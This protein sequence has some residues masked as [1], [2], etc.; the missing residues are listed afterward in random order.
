MHGTAELR[1]WL[2]LLLSISPA[3]KILTKFGQADGRWGEMGKIAKSA[4]RALNLIHVMDAFY[5]NLLGQRISAVSTT[6]VLS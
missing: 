4:F 2:G 1:W 5:C 3:S 6:F